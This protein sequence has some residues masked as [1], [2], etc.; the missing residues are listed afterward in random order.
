MGDVD[1][2]TLWGVLVW[3][4]M[5]AV[6]KPTLLGVSSCNAGVFLEWSRP[7][8]GWVLFSTFTL[9]DLSSSDGVLKM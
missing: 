1:H 7:T 2:G 9:S 6:E 4:G 5:G 3:D 8:R